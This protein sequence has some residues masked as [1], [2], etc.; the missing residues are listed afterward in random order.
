MRDQNRHAE[1]LASLK[2]VDKSADRLVAQSLV[3][4]AQIQQVGVVRDYR[5]DAGFDA[6]VL[7]ASDFLFGKWFRRPLPRRLGEYLDA[8]AADLLPANQ[9]LAYAA[10]NRHLRSEQRTTGF[11]LVCHS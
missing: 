6:V 3:W 8:F 2:L 10:G 4:C 7:E 5:R 11:P 9:R 1:R